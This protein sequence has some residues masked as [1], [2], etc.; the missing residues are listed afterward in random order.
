M[1]FFFCVCVRVETAVIIL[2]ESDFAAHRSSFNLVA[3]RCGIATDDLTYHSLNSV[4]KTLHF[5]NSDVVSC[6]FM[7]LYMYMYMKM[8]MYIIV[9]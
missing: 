8:Y 4:D 5:I 6:F 3:G 9:T 1:A 7:F 2:L